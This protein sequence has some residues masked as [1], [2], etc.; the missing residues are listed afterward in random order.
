VDVFVLIQSVMSF[1]LDNNLTAIKALRFFRFFRTM[2][3]L[4][5]FGAVNRVPQL[6]VVLTALIKSSA[7]L[8][9]ILLVTACYILLLAIFL[10]IIW[11]DSFK[12]HCLDDVTGEP[13]QVRNSPR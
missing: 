7:K 13:V 11:Q 6:R 5:A 10:C 9:D 4:R 3:G 2:R 8:R 1:F 12:W